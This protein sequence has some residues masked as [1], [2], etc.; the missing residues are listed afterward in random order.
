MMDLELS[1]EQQE[2]QR[3]LRDFCAAEI[4]PRAGWIDAQNQFDRDLYRRLGT[5]GFVG[6]MLPEAYGGSSSDNLTW[7]LV[8]EELAKA[9]SAIANALVLARSVGDVILALGDEDQRRRYL[10]PLASGAA[11]YGFGLTESQ[12]GSDAAAIRTA[13]RRDRDQY[14]LN[15]EKMFTT[16]GGIADAVIVAATLDRAQGAGAI[17][18]FLVP[19]DAA[20]FSRGGKLDLMGVRGMETCPL[21]LQDCRLPRESVLGPESAGFKALMRA[22]DGGRLGIAAMATGLAQAAMDAAL[23]HALQRVQF[24]CPLAEMPAI[25]AMLAD[26]SVD[27]EAARL[28]TQRAAWRRDR[29]HSYSK[30]ASQA[31]L[32][33]AEICVTQVS[34]ALQIFG[35]YGY[36]K[37]LP[38]E[39]YYRDARIH[40]IWDGTSQVQRMIIA[41]HLRREAQEDGAT[42]RA[43]RG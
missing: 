40:Q 21:F 26:M 14:L 28:L 37:E 25:E 3:T 4:A 17:R 20:G 19:A 5:L 42:G 33:A 15:G 34:N 16:L 13:A 31:K 12:A 43:G 7:C 11:I 9:S 8:I 30:A 24:G 10:P 2:I 32:F 23:T 38:I 6:M 41:R 1:R 18:A 35:G 39:R 27:I 29:G 22:L 36:S